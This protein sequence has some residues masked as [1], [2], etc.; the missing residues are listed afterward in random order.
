MGL[1]VIKRNKRLHIVDGDGTSV[2][3]PTGFLKPVQGRH[4]LE[5]LARALEAG[6]GIR[7]IMAFEAYHHPG[8]SL[9]GRP[10]RDPVT[11]LSPSEMARG[12]WMALCAL[13]AHDPENAESPGRKTT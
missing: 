11:G 2:Y 5:V 3:T 1:S 13:R 7:A 10:I 6:D 8:R 12:E 9:C 4:V